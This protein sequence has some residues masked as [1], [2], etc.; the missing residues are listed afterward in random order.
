MDYCKE[1]DIDFL[2]SP[3]DTEAV[4]LLED[5]GMPVYKIG[6]G[7]IDNLEFLEYIA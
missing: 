3:Y 6:S 4:D 2:S 5:L 7:E 1:I